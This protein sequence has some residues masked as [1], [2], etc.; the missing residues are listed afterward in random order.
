MQMRW[1]HHILL[2]LIETE[3]IKLE[4]LDLLSL[5][6]GSDTKPFTK[7]ETKT[8]QHIMQGQ[9]YGGY[10][11]LLHTVMEFIIRVSHLFPMPT[12]Y[13]DFSFII[14][15]GLP[16]FFCKGWIQY[17]YLF[18]F[19]SFD[20]TKQFSIYVGILKTHKKLNKINSKC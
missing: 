13:K 17:A 20:T 10:E 6:L 11:V 16:Y 4:H 5:G 8:E 14:F 12:K 18:N 9:Q 2:F 3:G 15:L 1:C 7:L 19:L